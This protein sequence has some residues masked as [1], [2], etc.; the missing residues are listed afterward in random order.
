ML[1]CKCGSYNLYS[2]W[3]EGQLV[4][5]ECLVVCGECE[6]EARGETHREA[7]AIWEKMMGEDKPEP[8][9][10]SIISTVVSPSGLIYVF[11][12]DGSFFRKAI[13]KNE[14][15]TLDPIPGTPADKEKP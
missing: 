1:P 9:P 5:P 15:D 13:S 14:W 3:D 11:C 12:K 10:R 8:E 7:W 2:T 6:A 4:N